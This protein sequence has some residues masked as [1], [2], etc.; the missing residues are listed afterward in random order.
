MFPGRFGPKTARRQPLEGLSGEPC[1]VRIGPVSIIND[2][3]CPVGCH[4]A[5]GFKGGG[6]PEQ[7]VASAKPAKW[8]AEP[9]LRQL[10]PI[11]IRRGALS[12]KPGIFR[13]VPTLLDNASHF[14]DQI[15]INA[16]R[17]WPEVGEGR[18]RLGVSRVSS[19]PHGLGLAAIPIVHKLRTLIR[20]TASRPPAR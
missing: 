20:L 8:S 6:G 18:R 19:E 14:P 1:G 3:N 11:N 2:T 13:F 15:R 17:R 9:T 7:G 16:R 12:N 5:M 10:N 4:P